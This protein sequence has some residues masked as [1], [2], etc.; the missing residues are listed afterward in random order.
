MTALASQAFVT[1]LHRRPKPRTAMIRS[2]LALVLL[3]GIF[4]LADESRAAAPGDRFREAA[5]ALLAEGR[6]EIAAGDHQAALK[7]LEAALVADPGNAE[8]MIA[9]GEAH[10]AM[11]RRKIALGY[12]RR[13][14]VIEPTSRP[15]LLA[16]SLA[17]IAD[18]T[19]E[20]AEENLE[21]L[22][23]LCAGGPCEEAD[24]I[25]RAL[26]EHKAAEGSGG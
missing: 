2:V 3:S 24:R 17:L 16:E 25:A 13:A 11:E 10:E 8:T 20:K 7:L 6:E 15:A 4:A 19:P 22:R 21:R 23:R 5:R 12:Y 9:I 18:N 1:K 26:A 14:L